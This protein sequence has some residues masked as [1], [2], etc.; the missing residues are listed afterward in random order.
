LVDVYPDGSAFNLA[1]GIVRAKYRNSQAN[2]EALVP[3]KVYPLTIDLLA[4]QQPVS[5]GSSH[6]PGSLQQQFPAL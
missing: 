5:R 2:A 1:E 4:T 3:V 6:S